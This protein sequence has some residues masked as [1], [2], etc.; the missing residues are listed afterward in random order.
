MRCSKSIFSRTLVPRASTTGVIEPALAGAVLDLAPDPLGLVLGAG[1][2]GNTRRPPGTLQLGDPPGILDE[3]LPDV[4]TEALVPHGHPGPGVAA[5]EDV[6][7]LGLDGGARC[8][9]LDGVGHC[10]NHRMPVNG[11]AVH[12]IESH[13]THAKM[14][15]CRS[16]GW[17]PAVYRK[18]SSGH[19]RPTCSTVA[20]S[21]RANKKRDFGLTASERDAFLEGKACEIC[22]NTEDLVPDHCHVTKV[23][24]GVLCQQHNRALGLLG[25]TV[26]GVRRALAYLEKEVPGDRPGTS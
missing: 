6:H 11:R 17:V 3:H 13:S 18:Q 21:R 1:V 14:V 9:H 5:G 23:I 10:N 22:G 20:R 19:M 16:C 26:E 8:Q 2:L 24:R 25:D 4:I 15:R 7:R 12:V